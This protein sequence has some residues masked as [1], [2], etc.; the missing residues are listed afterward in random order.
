VDLTRLRRAGAGNRMRAAMTRR[1]ALNYEAMATLVALAALIPVVSSNAAELARYE[2]VLIDLLVVIGLNMSFGYAG[3]I[4]LG[5]PVIAGAAAYMAGVLSVTENF[6][7]WITLPLAVVTGVVFAV[8]LNSVSFRLRGWY[9][10][11]TTFFA[12]TV[13]PDLVDVFQHWTQGDNGLNGIAPIP[14]AAV[15]I[16]GNSVREYEIVLAITAI[17]WLAT[18]NLVTSRWGLMLESLRDCHNGFVACGGNQVTVRFTMTVVSA[19]PVGVAG[20]LTAHVTMF[21]VPTSFG[22]NQLLLYAGAV[23]LGGRGTIWGPVVGTVV[24]EGISLWIGPFSVTNEIVLGVSVLVIS[25]V[26]PVGLTG[27]AGWVYAWS[28][29]RWTRYRQGRLATRAQGSRRW[30]PTSLMTPW[31]S[32]LTDCRKA[33]V[34]SRR[35]VM[36]TWSC[37]RV[38]SPGSSGRTGR[39]RRHCSM[40]LPAS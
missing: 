33:S 40:S 19:I 17:V 16:D 7:A 27:S 21:L 28:K 10:A 6:S 20:W 8:V 34:A 9:L 23:I 26:S 32:K 4:S 11:A 3:L 29:G 22:L 35:S 12:V 15:G 1:N 25:A 13:F 2:D 24:F 36:L 14:G 39:V 18:T 31:Y 30:H 38:A 37:G 5:Q